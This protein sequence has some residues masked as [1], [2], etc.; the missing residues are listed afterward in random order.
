MLSFGVLSKNEMKLGD[1]VYVDAVG[2]SIE[3][4]VEGVRSMAAKRII[5]PTRG[6]D[7]YKNTRILSNLRQVFWRDSVDIVA[8]L[9]GNSNKSTKEYARWIDING[10]SGLW[11]YGGIMDSRGRVAWELTT[12]SMKWNMP[13]YVLMPPITG[14]P[15]VWPF[16]MEWVDEEDFE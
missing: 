16:I 6:N 4:V 15:Q 11:G 9:T 12:E 10:F 5:A 13:Q 1:I 14:D 3:D 8:L 7:L 2:L